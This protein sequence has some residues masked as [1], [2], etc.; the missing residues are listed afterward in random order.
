MYLRRDGSLLIGDEHNHVIRLV[1]PNGTI[2]TIAGTGKPS[3]ILDST[4]RPQ[5]G[6][7]DPEDV[8]ERKDGSILIADRL[9]RR[10]VSI[11]PDGTVAI[12]AGR[13]SQAQAEP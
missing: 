4:G 8:I 12:F 3:N 10:I 6:L 5:I 9:N 7:N 11:K 2:S 13:T 1:D